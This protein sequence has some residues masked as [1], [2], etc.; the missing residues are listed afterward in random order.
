ML[1]LFVAVLTDTAILE[2]RLSTRLIP[3][4]LCRWG[5]GKTLLL[6]ALGETRISSTPKAA[7]AILLYQAKQ[8]SL[9]NIFSRELSYFWRGDH[10][11]DVLGPF[12]S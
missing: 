4:M 10:K 11:Y 9:R 6:T 12:V 1:N 7:R 3:Y 8:D 2:L 5:E